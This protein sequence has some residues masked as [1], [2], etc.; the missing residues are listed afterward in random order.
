MEPALLWRLGRGAG[1]DVATNPI[2]QELER[3]ISVRN[4]A[5]KV[6]RV[7]EISRKYDGTS[8]RLLGFLLSLDYDELSIVTCDPWKRACGGVPRNSVVAIKL[9]PEAV[10]KEDRPF[11]DRIMLARVT[12]SVPTP[13]Q[14]DIEGTV[15]QL[16]KVQAIP[17]PVTN[18]E[19]QWSALKATVVG[20]YYDEEDGD[21]GLS[22]AFGNDV[23][24]FFSPHAYQVFVPTADDLEVLINSFVEAADPL[25]IGEL[26]YTETPRAVGEREVVPVRV[27]PRDFV[28]HEYGN[29]TALFG[30]TRMG[31]S[32]TVKVIA[33]TI[34][35]SKLGVGQVIFDPSG[36]YTYV[37]PQDRTSLYAM[38]R[39]K[40]V[41][42]SLAPRAIS[43]E[44]AR[45]FPAPKNLRVNFYESV[46]VGHSLIQQLWDTT[47]AT[48]PNYMQPILNWAPPDLSEEPDLAGNPSGFAH[49]WRTMSMWFAL[50]RLSEF[51]PQRDD[52]LVPVNFKDTVKRHLISQLGSSLRLYEKG[53]EQKLATKQP[54]RV[55][56]A[57]Y[58]EVAVLWEARKNDSAWFGTTS[59]GSP[60]FNGAE[61]AMLR[62]LKDDGT[63]SGKQYFVPFKGYHDP[64]GSNTFEEISGHVQAG[65]TVV[66]DFARADEQVRR[67]LSE[68]ICQKILADMMRLFGDD[69]LGDRFV[70]LYFEEA[71]ELFPAAD[72]DLNNV[73]NKLAKE[74]AKF[75]I[76][77]V[78]ATQS[79]TTLSPDL[80]KN[81]ENFF[82]AHLDDD[83][84]VKEVT[85]KY[86][87][88]D[89]AEDVQRTMSKGFVRMITQS[90]R[91]ALPVQIRKFEPRGSAA[92]PGSNGER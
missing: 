85:R 86:A 53:G 14:R 88:R 58:R 25:T 38:H 84:E 36:E 2:D 72:R 44:Q 20:T 64:A 29:R 70:V 91:F 90:H 11:C 39:D 12:D 50:L 31:K 83:R 33:D 68:R 74:G 49:F 77:M 59:D 81:T 22:V 24:T 15:F 65:K 69:E 51:V 42:Y 45:G 7:A 10:D 87:F 60:Y 43:S 54:L 62:I 19:L 17:D 9:G 30:K 73:Y 41:R 71:H 48:K 75:H 92:V 32:N 63:I 27:D 61:Q 13:I 52:D 82:I 57:I 56:P 18:K 28:G 23:D 8:R 80:L 4:G 3:K 40:C 5:E 55:L 79:M 78:Y 1:G 16:H 89:V 26:R 21:G 67:N 76:S 47:H 37:N 34:L 66:V 46:P 6:G 35:S